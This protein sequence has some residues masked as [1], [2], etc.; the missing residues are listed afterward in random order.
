MN[1]G[2]LSLKS[3]TEASEAA[4]EET[5]GEMA[6]QT[7]HF[8]ERNTGR[9]RYRCRGAELSLRSVLINSC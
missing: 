9:S 3:A 8:K 2:E 5:Y 4:A 6:E 1:E 7:A